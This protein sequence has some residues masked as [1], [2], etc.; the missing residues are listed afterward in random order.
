MP[1][2]IISLNGNTVEVVS[3]PLT[4]GLQSIDWSATTAVAT[5]TSVFTGQVQVQRWPGADMWSG[6]CTLP[7]MTRAQAAP[8][9]AALQ[10]L[11]G[12]QNA[13]QI[14][15]PLIPTPQGNPQGA[16][17]VDSSTPVSAGSTS[18]PTLGWVPSQINLLLPGDIIQV[19]FRMHTVLD[20]VNSDANGKAVINVWPSLRE[21]PGGAITTSNALGLFRLAKNTVTWSTD[22][23]KLTH[24]SFSITEYR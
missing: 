6:T 15:D 14:G 8:W 9:R 16:P 22:Y 23:T 3:L 24:L 11:Q 21:V 12:M 5:V 7:P 19:G 2:S 18:L 10:Q 4:P 20:P 13:F 17:A 1:I